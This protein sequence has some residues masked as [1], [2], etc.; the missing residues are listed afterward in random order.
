MGIR[1]RRWV[2]DRVD[3]HTD[4]CIS[5]VRMLRFPHAIEESKNNINSAKYDPGIDVDQ[6]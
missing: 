3:V 6:V 4:Q 2:G 1:S 5:G